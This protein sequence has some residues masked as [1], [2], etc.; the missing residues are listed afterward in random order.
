MSL[1]E[2]LDLDVEFRLFADG[3]ALEIDDLGLGGD[4]G[5]GP[6]QAAGPGFVGDDALGEASCEVVLE[7]SRQTRAPRDPRADHLND[8]IA[9]Q[10]GE[11]SPGGI[12]EFGGGASETGLF[13]DCAEVAQKREA[14]VQSIRF[15]AVAIDPAAAAGSADGQ[16]IEGAAAGLQFLGAPERE[17]PAFVDTDEENREVL[18]PAGDDALQ[19]RGDAG[20]GGTRI[21]GMNQGQPMGGHRPNSRDP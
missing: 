15:R 4:G 11:G 17:I 16:E 1:V 19:P 5:T 9:E 3:R 12:M 21:D 6:A 20:R 2:T 7:P 8:R 10:T 14:E 13:A 18:G